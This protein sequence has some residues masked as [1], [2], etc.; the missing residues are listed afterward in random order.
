MGAYRAVAIQV[1]TLTGCLVLLAASGRA[2]TED[3]ANWSP[4]DRLSIPLTNAIETPTI[5]GEESSA[6]NTSES[7]H[8]AGRAADSRGGL[9]A[10]AGGLTPG[11]IKAG[12]DDKDYWW[13]RLADGGYQVPFGAKMNT[14]NA[15]TATPLS[16]EDEHTYLGVGLG[17][18]DVKLKSTAVADPSIADHRLLESGLLYR[19]F[20]NAPDAFLSPYL[21]AGANL[22]TLV[23]NYRNAATAA[24][25]ETGNPN[26]LWGM[27][28]Y[29]G[30]GLAFART[31]RLSFFGE[32][33][34]GGTALL[35]Q[36][37]SSQGF[38]NGILG[39]F[40]Y[41]GMKAGLN[42]HF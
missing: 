29:A 22:Q 41:V 18:T 27:D 8:V 12:G 21:S 26:N 5:P 31:K 28:G 1:C 6:S 24:A 17:G 20:L 30:L 42:L 11:M 16:Y 3:R 23:W 7:N 39:N 14:P 19:C 10:I 25:A 33:D 15:Y 4:G 34:V 9:D 36:S 35:P 2:G 13:Q 32:A 40:G 38:N 37:Q